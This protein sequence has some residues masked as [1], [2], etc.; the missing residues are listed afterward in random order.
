[1]VASCGLLGDL[2]TTDP[3]TVEPRANLDFAHGVGLLSRVTGEI[4]VHPMKRVRTRR[5]R[6]GGL[7]HPA[8]VRHEDGQQPRVA[9]LFGRLPAQDALDLLMAAMM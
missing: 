4:R 6:W 7:G 9:D 3:G 8:Q 5:R 1:L 2:E